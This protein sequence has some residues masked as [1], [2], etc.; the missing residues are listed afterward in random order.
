LALARA[1]P[2]A[3]VDAYDIDQATVEMARQNAAGYPDLAGRLTVTLLDAANGLPENGYDA[4]F[5]FEC[6]HD[7]ARPVEVLRAARRALRPGG[8]VIVMDEAVGDTYAEPGDE[9][10]RLMYGFSL[11]VCLPDGM[12][13]PPSAATGTVM[14][15]HTL[16]AY[17]A[18]AGLTTFEILPIEDFGFW[19]FY[20]LA[21]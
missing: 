7:M 17:A 14:R 15:P 2:S 19:R 8:S 20:R 13:H 1:Y 12:S 11:F 9:I 6:V 10:E 21:V 3:R 16:R 4:V 5:A 18:E